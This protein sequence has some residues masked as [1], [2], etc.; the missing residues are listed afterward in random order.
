MN[1]TIEHI[2]VERLDS[3]TSQLEDLTELVNQLRE[4]GSRI[5]AV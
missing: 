4:F 5:T 2:S 3:I 1:Q